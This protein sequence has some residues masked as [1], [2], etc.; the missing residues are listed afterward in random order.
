MIE[1]SVENTWSKLKPISIKA[2]RKISKWGTSVK[3]ETSKLWNNRF[4]KR[5][6]QTSPHPSS[7][8]SHASP[9]RSPAVCS[10]RSCA[11]KDGKFLPNSMTGNAAGFNDFSITS[12]DRCETRTSASGGENEE[13]RSRRASGVH[14]HHKKEDS[15]LSL[16]AE[17]L[18]E[19]IPHTRG[20]HH[21]H[22]H[23]T[24]NTPW[25]HQYS[26]PPRKDSSPENLRKRSSPR[27]RSRRGSGI[28]GC[29]IS[30]TARRR[31]STEWVTVRVT[32]GEE[33]NFDEKA[34]LGP[35]THHNL[36]NI[37][38][39]SHL[40]ASSSS[41]GKIGLPPDGLSLRDE[42][43]GKEKE[44]SDAHARHST[45]GGTGDCLSKRNGGSGRRLKLWDTGQGP[46]FFM[47]RVKRRKRI[48]AGSAGGE[49]VDSQ[50]DSDAEEFQQLTKRHEMLER[51]HEMVLE[52]RQ[53]LLAELSEWKSR[54][55]E[56]DGRTTA[57]HTEDSR[58]TFKSAEEMLSGSTPVTPS[59]IRDR[60]MIMR[61]MRRIAV[62]AEKNNDLEDE[63]RRK[64][65]SMYKLQKQLETLS[66]EGGSPSPFSSRINS[67]WGA[68]A[69]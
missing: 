52:E 5:D 19:S 15:G 45:E 3:G 33:S 28:S 44:N 39:R 4:G 34:T 48:L 16:K 12:S 7:Y 31:D 69:G 66:I 58:A 62:E 2:G 9:P 57:A 35:R 55:S 41:L 20:G 60:D 21:H 27:A 51:E 43:K 1:T 24:H 54:A 65:I 50:I 67:S 14:G 56:T 37:S 49:D 32:G 38:A 10:M 22:Q 47:E 59:T 42:I 13:K 68:N 61:L 40:S 53:R 11:C 23:S 46:E 29:V 17:L 18:G 8:T 30:P 64:E 6:S 26:P 25:T 36:S 63:V